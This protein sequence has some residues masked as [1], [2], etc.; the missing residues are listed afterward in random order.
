MPLAGITIKAHGLD[1]VESRLAL[2]GRGLFIDQG[3]RLGEQ[4]LPVHDHQ[5]GEPRPRPEPGT[6]EQI[7]EVDPMKAAATDQG[8]VGRGIAN[9]VRPFG[10]H[11]H[12]PP[13]ADH[14]VP[15]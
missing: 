7:L 9:I 1:Q 2:P 6:A 8:I 13:G 5:T 11:H 12:C 4:W 10:K 3:T 15:K 14:L